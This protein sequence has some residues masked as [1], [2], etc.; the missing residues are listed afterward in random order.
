M[1]KRLFSVPEIEPGRNEYCM[2]G[3][4]QYKLLWETD[5]NLG[6]V[7]IVPPHHWNFGYSLHSQSTPVNKLQV[8]LRD[9]R[10]L[11]G[12]QNYRTWGNF[13]NFRICCWSNS[14]GLWSI[15]YLQFWFL[16]T[17][18]WHKKNKEY[19]VVVLQKFTRKYDVWC[20]CDYYAA[21]RTTRKAS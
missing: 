5:E 15:L 9:W 13:A 21:N 14:G 10:E 1:R 18:M 19:F 20:L 8:T 12:R 17:D 4:C 2:R 3:W 6:E 7:K 11:W 16:K